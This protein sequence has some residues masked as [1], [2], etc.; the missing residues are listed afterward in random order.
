MFIILG[1]DISEDS[2]FS[3][4]QKSTTDIPFI[5]GS[6]LLTGGISFGNSTSFV[7][8]VL[9]FSMGHSISTFLT[10]SQRSAL[11]LTSLIKPYL[12][13]KTIYA[14]S[15]IVSRTVPRASIVSVVPLHA[16][17]LRQ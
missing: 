8:F 4:I 13:C 14:P 10:C 7:I 15:S 2:V 6:G 1:V 17:S 16:V 11:V 3:L 5:V 9:P 12:T